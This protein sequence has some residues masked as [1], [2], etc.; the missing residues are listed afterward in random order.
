MIGQRL[1]MARAAARI[2]IEELEARL[3][4]E[5]TAAT[6]VRYESDEIMPTSSVLLALARILDVSVSFLLSPMEVVIIDMVAFGEDP[7]DEPQ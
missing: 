6:L 5:I 1:R 3:G 4:R 7:A 2:S